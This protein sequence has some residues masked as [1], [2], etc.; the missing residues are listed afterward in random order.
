MKCDKCQKGIAS[1]SFDVS[2]I[3]SSYV[4]A[5]IRLCVPCAEE[6]IQAAGRDPD[7]MDFRDERTN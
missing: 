5:E 4:V 3:P 2:T 7:E 1:V 6:V